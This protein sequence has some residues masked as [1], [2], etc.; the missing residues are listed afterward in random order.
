MAPK[1][2]DPVD[3]AALIHVRRGDRDRARAVARRRGVSVAP[4]LGDLLRSALDAAEPP[5]IDATH[6]P[7]VGL[8]DLRRLEDTGIDALAMSLARGS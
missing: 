4:V 3:P 2:V 7:I 1:L 8:D 5:G 6:A